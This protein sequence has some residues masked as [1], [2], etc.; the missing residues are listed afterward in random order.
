MKKRI[1]AISDTHTRLKEMN[2][3]DGDILIH[4]GDACEFGTMAE[5]EQFGRD[6]RALPHKHKLFIPGN[7][8]KPFWTEASEALALLG[9]SITYF[10]FKLIEVMGLK[11]YGMPL[12]AGMGQAAY[13]AFTVPPR[14]LEMSQACAAI[15]D[16]LDVLVTHGPPFGVRDCPAAG[17]NVGCTNLRHRVEYARPKVHIFG[18]VHS[19]YGE[20]FGEEEGGSRIH[21]VNACSSDRHYEPKNPPIII[22]VD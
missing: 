4:A 9:D 6:M 5:V 18:H 19:N 11:I 7:H 8:D 22:E 14:S 21:F 13:N 12:V 16:D 15:P 2:V 3:P 10:P 17:I 1:V 20:E